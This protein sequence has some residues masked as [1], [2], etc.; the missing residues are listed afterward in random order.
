MKLRE[1]A[2]RQWS[3]SPIHLPATSPR[4]SFEND[5]AVEVGRTASGSFDSAT[6]DETVSGIA[7]DDDLRGVRFV[8]DQAIA[9]VI[10]RPPAAKP[11]LLGLS[12]D[13]REPAAAKGPLAKF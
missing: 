11:G 12:A 2:T 13:Q 9:A 4:S 1:W 10:L 7:Q 8:V 5:S 6:N 3:A